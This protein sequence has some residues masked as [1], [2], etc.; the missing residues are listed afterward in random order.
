ME[1]NMLN[2]KSTDLNINL[3][4]QNSFREYAL[5]KLMFNQT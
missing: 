1:D 3:I 2:S 4:K 5:T